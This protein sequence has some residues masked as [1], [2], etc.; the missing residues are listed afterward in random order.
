MCRLLTP[1]LAYLSSSALDNSMQICIETYQCKAQAALHE[2]KIC[3]KQNLRGSR[4]EH[5]RNDIFNVFWIILQSPL[6]QFMRKSDIFF[7]EGAVL[8]FHLQGLRGIIASTGNTF[9]NFKRKTREVELI[10]VIFK[11]A[12][13]RIA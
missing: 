9:Y 6:L 3:W 13:C 8:Y 7:C 11:D 4:G 2:A 10:F 1:L 5:I 12:A